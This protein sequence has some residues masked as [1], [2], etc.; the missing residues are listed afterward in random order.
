MTCSPGT[1]SPVSGEDPTA[2]AALGAALLSK[3]TALLLLGILPAAAL[4]GGTGRKRVFPALLLLFA[5]ALVVVHVGYLPLHLRAPEDAPRTGMGILPA[6]YASGIDY[7][8]GA[9]TGYPSYF[10]GRVSETG[11]RAYYPVAFLVKTPVPFLLLAAAGA[12]RVLRRRER[13]HAA[14][15][16]VPP[17]LL[18]LFFVAVSRINIGWALEQLGQWEDAAE[19]LYRAIALSEQNGFD[20]WWQGAT[21][22]LAELYVKRSRL[23][24]AI[25]MLAGVVARERSKAVPSPVL[26]TA[27]CNLGKAL[28]R[29]GDFGAAAKT[30]AEA[31][32][33]NRKTGNRRELAIL[34]RRMA[35]LALTRGELD[36]AEECVGRSAA[37][38]HELG[39]KREQGETLRVRALLFAEQGEDAAARDCFERA[40]AH[41]SET[42]N[43]YEMARIRL[44]YGRYLAAAAD[45]DRALVLLKQAAATF[46]ASPEITICPGQL[47]LAICAP[48]AAHAAAVAASSSPITAAIAPGFR[49]QAACISSPRRRTRRRP[50]SKEKTPAAARAVN[51]PRE[52]PAAASH[53][54]PGAA[55]LRSRKAIHPVR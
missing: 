8:R 28:H 35:E 6:P 49:S 13:A 23:K 44:Q 11:W 41:L 12:F 33:L 42:P 47:R 52:S 31:L 21:T 10:F 14:W 55:S 27:L 26:D 48:C 15:L 46:R 37:I 38:A 30:Y 20:F 25:D 2:G 5:A 40:I 22:N 43:S 51:S 19:N 29:Q 16:L 17:L 7:Q 4:L 50:S 45:R 54:S 32:A 3:Y 36:E 53:S 34:M 39:L 24:Q 1:R 9:N 18:A